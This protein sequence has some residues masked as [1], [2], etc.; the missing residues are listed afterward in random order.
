M[1]GGRM[2]E[3]SDA[4]KESMKNPIRNPSYM[5]VS[6]G[7]V[8]DSAQSQAVL[9]NQTQYAGFSDLDGVFTQ[10]E[11]LSQYATYEN[12]FW[13]LDGSMRFLPDAASQYEPYGI[14][15]KNLFSSSFSV[16]MT[17]KEKVDIAGLTIKF[18][19]N[20][21]SKFSVITS[22]GTTKTYSNSSLEFVTDD[23][24]D[25]TTSL[26]IKVTS[27][28]ATSNRV[29][30]ESILFGNAIVFTGEEILNAESTS[31]MSQ[32]NEDLPE[33]NFNLTIDNNDKRFDY[34][35]KSSIIN[36]LRTGQ[37]VV[38]QMGYELDDETIEWM[39]LHTLKL[40]EW[41]A[42]DEEASIT[43]VDV[44]QQ[45]GDGD[46]YRGDWHAKGITLYALANYVIADAI[47]TYS[48]PQDKFSIDKY[49]QSVEVRNPLPVVSHK[50]ALQ[51]I[52]NAGRCILTVDRYGKICIKS[53]FDPDSETTSTETAYF[54]NVENVNIDNEKT[55][56]A[57]YEE[58]MWKLSDRPPF[59]PR[60]GIRNDVGFVTKDTAPKGGTFSTP[61]QIIKTFEVP[62]KSNGMKIKVYYLFP[63]TMSIT[64]Y[65]K[66]QI[67]ESIGISDGK[68]TSSN[69]VRTWTTD[70]QFKTFDKMVIEFGRINANTRLVVDYI[71]LGE[72][73]DY[74]IERDDMY[75]SPTMSKP[76]NIKRLK[77]IRT[78][79][80]KSNTVEEVLSEEVE[81]TNETLLY[82]FDE[83]HHSYTASLEN[84]S[85]GQSVEISDSGAYFV[86]LQLSGND[87]GKNVQVIVNG[88][89]FNQ[90]KAYSVEEIS[91]YGVEKDWSN[92][93]ISD[94]QLCDTVCK[95]VADYYKPGIDYSIDY[96]GEPALDAGDT[97]YQENRDSEM[98]K[99]VAES[100]S[101]TFDGTVSGTLE[102]RRI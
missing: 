47:G 33:I 31:T 98:V 62:R 12:N 35:N 92:P 32:I 4:Y 50:E 96:R 19:G 8:N 13:V 1:R 99:T 43:A 44:L 25:N 55:R 22:D 61:P 79:Y 41:S 36:Y 101:M 68:Q 97:I 77:N 100:V 21:P 76:E 28:S 64:T 24:F 102:T 71:E 58:T 51:M 65:L 93:L 48:I 38:V 2:Y 81:W 88:K 85:S 27:M 53:A 29:R 42:S 11:A 39:P 63:K 18:T 23:R 14:V 91:N 45:F 69:W 78:V 74:T 9:S 84:A 57:T 59:L 30:I 73:I 26:E 82:T 40:S 70:H 54:S 80:S 60:T 34:D 75:S 86:E 49:L 67:V 52:A 90:S 37:D 89:K 20:H 94:K 3:V 16:K 46:Y 10:K 6:L 95:W 15:S 5:K 66:D 83:P 87:S 56:Y 7:V 72:N 17:F